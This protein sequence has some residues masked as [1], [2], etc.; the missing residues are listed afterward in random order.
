MKSLNYN[1]QN[2]IKHLDIIILQE[3]WGKAD[4][5]RKHRREIERDFKNPL[6]KHHLVKEDEKQRD[7]QRERKNERELQ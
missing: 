4:T 6:F 1:F 3:T 5:V 2:S 7:R